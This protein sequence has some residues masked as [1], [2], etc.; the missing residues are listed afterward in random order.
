MIL[1][2]R[3]TAATR[4]RL[5]RCIAGSTLAH[6]FVTIPSGC[7]QNDPLEFPFMAICARVKQEHV[8]ALDE[9]CFTEICRQHVDLVNNDL[10]AIHECQSN[11]LF[12][13]RGKGAPGI[14]TIQGTIRFISLLHERI[15]L[16][17]SRIHVFELETQRNTYTTRIGPYQYDAAQRGMSDMKPNLY[18]FCDAVGD[19]K[20]KLYRFRGASHR[21]TT[22][23]GSMCDRFAPRVQQNG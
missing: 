20:P 10:L 11:S 23:F 3:I 4:V 13:V 18:R 1:R 12:V 5:C 14:G 2:R 22:M 7:I 17:D 16:S 6:P 21:M 19:V 15:D 8:D 9:I